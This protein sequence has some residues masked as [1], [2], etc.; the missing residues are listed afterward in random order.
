MSLDTGHRL[1]YLDRNRPD[2]E[3]TRRGEPPEMEY[4]R[5]LLKGSTDSL[6]LALLID[7]PMYGYQ[8]VKALEQRSDGYFQFREGTLYPALHRLEKD[9]LLQGE[10]QPSPNGQKRRYYHVTDHGRTEMGARLSQW[11]GFTEAV[12]MVLAPHHA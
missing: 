6:L 3:Q 4:R 9:G 8:L 5:E 10:W 12:A 11:Q 1:G 2:F 7:E